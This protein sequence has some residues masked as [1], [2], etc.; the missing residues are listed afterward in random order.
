MSRNSSEFTEMPSKPIANFPE[1]MFWP[2]D[3][4]APRC[5]IAYPVPPVLR[6]PG[7]FYFCSPSILGTN[8]I[9]NKT[10]T[11]AEKF[12]AKIVTFLTLRTAVHL[13]LLRRLLTND[14]LTRLHISVRM[15]EISCP[16]LFGTLQKKYFKDGK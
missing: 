9:S 1:L 5:W 10:W 12:S 15:S 4:V 6:K 7:K 14:N 8:E 11:R 3:S 13:H 2:S 16:S